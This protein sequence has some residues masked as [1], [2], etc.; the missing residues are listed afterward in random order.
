GSVARKYTKRGEPYAQFRLEGLAAG[1]GV[2]AFPNVYEAVPDLIE[3]DRIVLAVGRID[4][5]G[6]ELQIRANEVREPDLGSLAAPSPIQ[7]ESLVVDL[8]AAACTPAVLAKLKDEFESHP[9]GTPVLVRFLSSSG[10]TPLEVGSFRVN[11]TGQLMGS[12]TSLLGSGAA[13]VEREA[14]PG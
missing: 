13:R 8:A 2:V 7:A 4:L 5:R 3:A 10:V 6:R 9:G 12:L 11:T 14:V 1:V